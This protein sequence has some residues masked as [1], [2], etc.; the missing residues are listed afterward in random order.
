MNK[1]NRSI[2]SILLSLVMLMSTCSAVMIPAY[3]SETETKSNPTQFDIGLDAKLVPLA[4]LFTLTP[5]ML[6]NGPY[7]LTIGDTSYTSAD[8]DFYY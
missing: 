3:A 1:L 6:Q 2:Q 8:V 5:Y 4:T 7:V